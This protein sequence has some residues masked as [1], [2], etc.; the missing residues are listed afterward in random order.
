[1]VTRRWTPSEELKLLTDWENGVKLKVTAHKLGRSITAVSRHRTRI[2]PTLTRG[3]AP[4]RAYN[5][6]RIHAEDHSYLTARS[7]R[8]GV[9]ITLYLHQLIEKDRKAHEPK[10]TRPALDA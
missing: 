9:S 6:V 1:M 4:S 2:D 5:G 8:A 3:W 10:S 7:G